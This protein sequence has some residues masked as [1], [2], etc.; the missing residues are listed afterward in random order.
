V[1]KVKEGA[2]VRGG[3]KVAKAVARA[4]AKVAARA[5]H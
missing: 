3:A 2:M 5:I 1:A 4:V